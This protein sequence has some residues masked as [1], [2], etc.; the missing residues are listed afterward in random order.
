M[1]N[2]VEWGL[3]SFDTLS[4]FFLFGVIRRIY[5]RQNTI[6][7]ILHTNMDGGDA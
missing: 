6:I 4:I 7:D 2:L 1:T 5:R 3:L